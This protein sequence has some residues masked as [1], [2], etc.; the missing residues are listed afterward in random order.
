[1]VIES[2]EIIRMGDVVGRCNDGRQTRKTP[3]DL[4]Y[5]NVSKDADYRHDNHG[6][7]SR[8]VIN[9]EVDLSFSDASSDASSDSLADASSDASSSQDLLLLLVWMFVTLL[10]FLHACSLP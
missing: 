5:L 4:R 6:H 7:K 2:V 9:I 10:P 1:M 8:K 3:I